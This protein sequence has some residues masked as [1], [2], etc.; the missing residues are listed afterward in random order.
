M[1][2]YEVAILYDPGLEVD[3]TKA[4]ERVKKIFTDNGGKVLSIDN[5]GKKKLAYPIKKH[6]HALYVFYQVSLDPKNVKQVESTLN[7][8]NEVIR[9]LIVKQDLKELEKI[10][11]LKLEKKTKIENRKGSGASNDRPQDDSEKT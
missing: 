6:D 8:T 7:I 2:Q 11:K 5:W 1:N 4:E 9:F 3:L 10:K